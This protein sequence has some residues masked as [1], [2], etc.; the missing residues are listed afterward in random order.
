MKTSPHLCTGS[1]L[2][3]L[4]PRDFCRWFPRNVTWVKVNWDG[5]VNMNTQKSGIGIIIRDNYKEV[6]ACQRS[7]V[8]CNSNPFLAESEA[9]FRSIQLCNELGLA[10]IRLKGD[11]KTVIDC[12][13]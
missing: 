3:Q 7:L 11:A 8:C 9:F 1:F 12:V 6:L 4:S 13:K 2:P 5:A 10:R